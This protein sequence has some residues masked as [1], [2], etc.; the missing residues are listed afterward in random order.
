MKRAIG[1]PAS[2]P[3]CSLY[4]LLSNSFVRE[5]SGLLASTTFQMMPSMHPLP[6]RGRKWRRFFRNNPNLLLVGFF[7]FIMLALVAAIF[8][9]L[10][11]PRFVNLHY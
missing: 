10:T 5:K 11:S 8:W 7:L 9:V 4:R 6:H 3:A 2:G 1:A